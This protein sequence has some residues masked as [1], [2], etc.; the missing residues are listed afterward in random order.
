MGI[1][2]AVAFC[3]LILFS[4][5]RGQNPFHSFR[6]SERSLYLAAGFVHSLAMGLFNLSLSVSLVVIV[7]PFRSM[8][9]IFVLLFSY[10]FLRELEKITKLIILGTV[11]TL[12]GG[13]LIS[14]YM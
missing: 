6:T 5:Y 8:S 14:I 10:F 2:F 11:L 7:M 9:P 1:I 13:I 3:S 12:I 4:L